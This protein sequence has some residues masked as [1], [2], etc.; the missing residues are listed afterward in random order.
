[1]GPRP[2]PSP[3]ANAKANPNANQ[4]LFVWGG[5]DAVHA[6]EPL[7]LIDTTSFLWN[8]PLTTGNEPT[9]PEPE[10]EPESEPE[11][12]PKPQP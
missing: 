10:P 1:M 9:E 12:E 7:H 8:K 3:N 4:E 2:N 11:S 5:G 6:H